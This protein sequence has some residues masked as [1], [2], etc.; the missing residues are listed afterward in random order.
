MNANKQTIVEYVQRE[1]EQ[2]KTGGIKKFSTVVELSMMFNCPERTLY[3]Y[4]SSSVILPEDLKYR[5]HYIKSEAISGENHPCY[6][7]K[8]ENHPRFG[9]HLTDQQKK[10]LSQINSGTNNPRYG[11][12]GENH[13]SYGKTRS[14]E[15]RR[16]IS[17]GLSGEN[18][19]WYGRI[20]NDH[21]R[22]GKHHTDQAKKR[23]A[24]ANLGKKHTTEAKTKMSVARMG[25]PRSEETRRKISQARLGEK[26]PLWNGGTSFL[27]YAP[28]FVK[29]MKEYIRSRDGHQCQFCDALEN[30]RKHSVHH[31]DHNKD[32][33]DERNLL[34]LC[35]ICH[36]NESTSTGKLKQEWVEWCT[37]K[38][39]E[40]YDNIP[41][42]KRDELEQL[43]KSLETRLGAA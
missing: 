40:I 27:P 15:I 25:V 12:R 37:E 14:E 41:A 23:L 10:H 1:I 18:N 21:T 4:I 6:G 32:N 8:G 7:K 3:T 36:N 5:T 29:V 17:A 16:K 2:H 39:Q 26:H 31:I 24:L 33:N 20:G 9:R 38:V 13:P 35:A 43:K 28:E 42:E 19:P 22:Y 11:V 34:T 30:E